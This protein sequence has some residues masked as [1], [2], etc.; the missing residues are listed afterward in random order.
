VIEG[1][2]FA[3]HADRDSYRNDRRRATALLTGGYA[4]LRFSWEDVRFRPEW[5]ID[6]VLTALRLGRPAC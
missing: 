6:Q 5:V 3:F 4:L 1:D 2:G